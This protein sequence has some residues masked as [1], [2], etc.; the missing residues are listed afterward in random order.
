MF[1]PYFVHCSFSLDKRTIF[2]DDPRG[3]RT[4]PFGQFFSI[5]WSS[6]T[7]HKSREQTF[8]LYVR[9]RGAK[10]FRMRLENCWLLKNCVEWKRGSE[11]PWRRRVAWL[12]N[13]S[14]VAHTALCYQNLLLLCFWA[15][16]IP[17]KYLNCI[18]PLVVCNVVKCCAPIVKWSSM[19]CF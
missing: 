6:Q 14:P 9:K 15:L 16:K 11:R 10:Y 1:Q 18:F 4:E 17:S 13:L 3:Y 8:E 5:W 2:N 19:M 12:S 7:P